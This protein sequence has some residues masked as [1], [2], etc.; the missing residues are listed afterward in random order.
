MGFA[1]SSA[2]ITVNREVF[3]RPLKYAQPSLEVRKDT[4][5]GLLEYSELPVCTATMAYKQVSMPLDE[6]AAL[7]SI[8]E[9]NLKFIPACTG[10]P[11][12]AELVKVANEDLQVKEAWVSS[13]EVCV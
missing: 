2:V 9:Y 5:V 7:M 11:S 3:G 4:L 10:A 6:A 12:V 8:P 13:A 1:D